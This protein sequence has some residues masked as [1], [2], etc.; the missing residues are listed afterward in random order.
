MAG[1]RRHLLNALIR[2]NWNQGLI[3][4][5]CSFDAASR[6]RL[7]KRLALTHLL[8]HPSN[9]CWT[10]RFCKV[11]PHLHS[12]RSPSEVAMMGG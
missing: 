1:L 5:E 10:L 8:Q 11:L 2:I 4:S 12:T 9:S 7:E 3:A 6:N